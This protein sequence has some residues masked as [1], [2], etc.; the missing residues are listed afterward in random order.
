MNYFTLDGKNYSFTWYHE[1]NESMFPEGRNYKKS[2][3]LDIGSGFDIE[4]TNFDIDGKHYATMYCWQWSFDELTVIGRTWAEFRE[5]FARIVKFY[6]PEKKRKLLV[7]IHNLPFEFSF[8][9]KQFDSL[10]HVLAKTK[11]EIMTFTADFVEFRDSLILT[12]FGLARM[13]KN[14]KLGIE[15]LK[16]D[17]DYNLVR[18]SSDE[19]QTPMEWKEIAYCINDVQILQKFFHKY[20][21]TE[22]LR[23]GYKI[24]LTQTAI[25]RSA[26]KRALRKK[27][28]EYVNKYRDFIKRCFPDAELYQYERR[29]AFRG[30]YTHSNNLVI[31]NTILSDVDDEMAGFDRKSSYP[32][33]ILHKKHPTQY[34]FESSDWFYLHALEPESFFD[35]IGFLGVFKIKNITAKYP[36]SI[37]SKHKLIDWD[38][39]T[40]FD[41]GRVMKSPEIMTMLTENDWL[42]YLDFYDFK[43]EDVECVWIMTTRKEYLPEF[44]IRETYSYFKAKETLPKDSLE[45]ARSKEKLNSIFGMMAT[46]LSE[47]DYIFYNGELYLSDDE[48]LPDDIRQEPRSY[49][50]LIKNCFLL[51][52]WSVS[53]AAGAR[54]ELLKFL[55]MTSPYDS[56]YCDTDSSKMRNYKKYLPQIEEYNRHQHELNVAASKRWNL[57]LDFIKD[58]GKFMKEDEYLK[59]RTLGC[60]RY[61]YQTKEDLQNHKES[62]IHAVVAGMERGSFL[63]WCEVNHKDPFE[64]FQDKLYL[65][66]EFS[67]KI[68]TAYTDSEF[69]FELTDYTGHTTT[70]HEKSCCALYA[71]PFSMKMDP[72]FLV[73]VALLKKKEERRK[74]VYKNVL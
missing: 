2:N 52:M 53:I 3:Y 13:A 64:S 39:G 37:E 55:I 33:E 63:N 24:P 71:I 17:L 23:N 50:S 62:E 34:F 41:N 16:G 15:K 31:N 21:K 1:F 66:P 6:K 19:Y 35:D 67:R 44:I 25:P 20:I 48:T 26:M 69:E 12:R 56:L 5:F 54:R 40:I 38:E 68:T 42:N 18:I 28:K 8:I 4:T 36:H 65:N 45:Y 30:G 27:G 49:E 51:P 61:L 46:G 59:F 32:S 29:Y 73:L 58:L 9:R 14:Y 43:M 7:F 11:R 10:D 70:I 57:D 72:N 22:F 47:S 60:K 74:E